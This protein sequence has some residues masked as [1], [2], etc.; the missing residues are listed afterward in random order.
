MDMSLEVN[1]RVNYENHNG[2][3]FETGTFLN[4][5][6]YIKHGNDIVYQNENVISDLANKE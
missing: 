6:V 4:M 1:C 2:I 5:V 3:V